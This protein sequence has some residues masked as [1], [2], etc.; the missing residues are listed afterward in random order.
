MIGLRF[1]SWFSLELG[2]DMPTLSNYQREIW[3]LWTEEK[4]LDGFQVI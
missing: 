3:S 1:G 4:C 2:A